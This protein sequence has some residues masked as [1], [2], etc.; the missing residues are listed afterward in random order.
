MIVPISI[1]KFKINLNIYLILLGI[2]AIWIIVGNLLCSCCVVNLFGG[3]KEGFSVDAPPATGHEFASS[4]APGWF[5][6]PDSWAQP[7]L[8]YSPDSKPDSGV[9]D[10]LD[11]PEIKLPLPEG[12][13]DL[14]ADMTFKPECC[15]NTYSSSTGCACMNVK[16]YNYLNERGGNNVP[17]SVF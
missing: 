10:I 16:T 8:S 4:T 12:Q 5:K 1:G 6:N 9:K 2:A 7:T 11:R 13:L 17:Y 3:N 14:F 15:P